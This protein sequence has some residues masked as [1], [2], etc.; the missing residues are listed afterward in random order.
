MAQM[1]LK[2]F[3]VCVLAQ[4]VGGV[5]EAINTGMVCECPRTVE[6]D[7]GI[8]AFDGCDEFKSEVWVESA[9]NDR[10]RFTVPFY[11]KDNE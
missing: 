1:E 9:S 3:I 5:N 2:D 4:I 10:L 7:I 8:E 11:S 6:F